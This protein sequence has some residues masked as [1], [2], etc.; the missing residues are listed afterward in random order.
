M[1]S[2]WRM[3]ASGPI[4]LDYTPMPFVLRMKGAARA[5]WPDLFEQVRVMEKAAVQE[6][7][8]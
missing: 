8:R 2:Q 3:G 7:Q 6:F 1:S 5:D 4:G